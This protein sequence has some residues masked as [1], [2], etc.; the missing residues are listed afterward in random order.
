MESEHA[1]PPGDPRFTRVPLC[2]DVMDVALPA[3][4]ELGGS[5]PV[6]LAALREEPWIL[7]PAGWQC[8]DVVLGACQAAGF[9]P[10]AA[11]RTSDW[12]AALRLVAAGLGVALIPR[13][14]QTFTPPAVVLR[15]VTG[16]PPCRHVFAAC[17]G[18][19]EDAPV[20]RLVLDTLAEVASGDAL[21]PRLAAAV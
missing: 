13:L 8:E 6:P 1:P 16:E 12:A 20:V 3:G 17:R 15:R 14:G 21:R 2:R 9:W 18:G 10:V 11:H 7:P 4:H 19:A 5:A